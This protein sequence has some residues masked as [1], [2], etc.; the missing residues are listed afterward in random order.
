MAEN[1]PIHLLDGSPKEC[2]SVATAGVGATAPGS[3]GVSRAAAEVRGGGRRSIGGSCLITHVEK[4]K[5]LKVRF[6]PC[7]CSGDGSFEKYEGR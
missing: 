1:M 5:E 2:V 4:K 7:E 6:K 3:V